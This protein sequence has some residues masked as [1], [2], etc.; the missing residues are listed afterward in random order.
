[1]APSLPVPF[2]AKPVEETVTAQAPLEISYS[3][4]PAPSTPMTT[5]DDLE[6]L[7][8]DVASMSRALDR[9][10]KTPCYLPE[11]K[12]NDGDEACVA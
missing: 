12:G 10:Q 3:K 9:S 8:Q 1:M 5:L 2:T 7:S 11:L 6:R 4:P